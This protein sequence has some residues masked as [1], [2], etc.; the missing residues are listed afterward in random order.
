MT[1]SD[2]EPTQSRDLLCAQC[3]TTPVATS[4][5][6]DALV[7]GS[8]DS[9]VTL[10]VRIP[11]R[12][13]RSCEFTYLDDEAEDIRH[14]A[15]CRHLGVLTPA[16]IRGIREAYGMSQADFARA[17]GLGEAT[18][19]RWENGLVIQNVANDLYLRLLRYD[20]AMRL[21]Q[22]LSGCRVSNPDDEHPV[23]DRNVRRTRKV[24]GRW[25]ALVPTDK[26]IR[27][28]KAFTGPRGPTPTLSPS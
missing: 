21:V 15:V 27:D 1:T 19:G 12:S 3:G 20:G 17:T 28:Q 14:N 25:R 4:W 13:C 23:S 16:E 6:D 8:G 22:Y 11:F 2:H 7:W 26:H 24:A 18:V 10:P 5:T 9:A